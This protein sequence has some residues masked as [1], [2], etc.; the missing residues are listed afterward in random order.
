MEL[1]L[2]ILSQFVH[3]WYIEMLMIFCKLILYPATLA[4]AVNGV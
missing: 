2:Y 1:F 4:V 3:C